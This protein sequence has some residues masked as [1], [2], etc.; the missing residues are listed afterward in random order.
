MGPVAAEIARLD[1]RVLTPTLVIVRAGH[2]DIGSRRGLS[3]GGSS[4][5]S[6]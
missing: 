4:K 3:N 5:P 6:P 1:L 2:D